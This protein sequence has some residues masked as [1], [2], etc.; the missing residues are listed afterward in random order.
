MGISDHY[1]TYLKIN[2]KNEKAVIKKVEKRD[3]KKIDIIDLNKII[4]NTNFIENDLGL[5]KNFTLMISSVKK[6]FD[7]VSPKKYYKLKS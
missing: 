7:E 2:Y 4:E 5:E 1:L 3:Y 6:I